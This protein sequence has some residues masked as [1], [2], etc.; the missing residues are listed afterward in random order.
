MYIITPPTYDFGV[1]KN[2]DLALQKMP[3]GHIRKNLINRWIG[4]GIYIHD[5]QTK[6]F[7]Y[8]F[9]FSLYHIIPVAGHGTITSDVL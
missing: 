3:L 9:M 5:F 2:V 1:A 7:S 8:M 6:P 4:W